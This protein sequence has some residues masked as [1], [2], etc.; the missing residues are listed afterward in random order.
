MLQLKRLHKFHGSMYYGKNKIIFVWSSKKRIMGIL[1]GWLDL[2]HV[3]F[4]EHKIQHKKRRQIRLYSFEMF[5]IDEEIRSS[6][7]ISRKHWPDQTLSSRIKI[8]ELEKRYLKVKQPR[9]SYIMYWLKLH[10]LSPTPMKNTFLQQWNYRIFA[11][12]WTIKLQQWQ[13]T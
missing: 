2:K 8:H 10:N 5:V 9:W 13:T 6:K 12:V 1:F 11:S 4:S 3:L 7:S